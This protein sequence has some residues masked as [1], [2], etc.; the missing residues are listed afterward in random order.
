MFGVKHTDCKVNELKSKL[1]D[2]SA[3]A[4]SLSTRQRM[5]DAKVD[6]LIGLV[7][8]VLETGQDPETKQLIKGLRERVKNLEAENATLKERLADINRRS[9]DP[10]VMERMRQNFRQ[11]Y[12]Y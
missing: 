1:L 12:G 9:R 3:E 10:E 7:S 4:Q 5:T 8:E 6:R 11:R 2:I